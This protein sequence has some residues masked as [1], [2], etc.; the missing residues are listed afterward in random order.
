VGERIVNSASE[1]AALVDYAQIESLLEV[2]GRRGVEEILLAFWRSTDDLV[3][4]LYRQ[5]ECD[6]FI[7]AA[8]SSHALKGS[9]ANVGANAL[10]D[11]AKD[12]EQC[13]KELNARS[14]ADALLR[15][16]RVYARTRAAI[17]ARLEMAA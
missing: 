10:A 2:A 7:E 11:A 4:R 6:D 15:L 1:N 13:S 17:N 12:V 3:Q 16:E 5:I 9:A 8:R 14:A